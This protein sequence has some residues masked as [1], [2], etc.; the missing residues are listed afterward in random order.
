[1]ASGSHSFQHAAGRPPT[2]ALIRL[3][4]VHP[5]AIQGQSPKGHGEGSGCGSDGQQLLP[6]GPCGGEA[7]GFLCAPGPVSAHILPVL[8]ALRG[9]TAAPDP[10]L[11][12]SSYPSADQ[13]NILPFSSPTRSLVW[14]LDT[15]RA[16]TA[17]LV[18]LSFPV[19]ATLTSSS[20]HRARFFSHLGP[21]RL[22]G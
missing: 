6:Q 10:P 2:C 22:G 17:G 7:W 21:L 9:N 20:L 19:K 14:F 12:L 5:C 11:S 15:A 1:M 8:P 18:L 16:V 4:E 3:I 13:Q